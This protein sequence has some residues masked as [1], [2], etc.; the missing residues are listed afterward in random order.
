MIRMIPVS[1]SLL[2]V[3]LSACGNLQWPPNSERNSNSIGSVGLVNAPSNHIMAKV[4]KRTE[5][6]VK[7]LRRRHA[8]PNSTEHIVAAGETLWRIAQV[9]NVDIYELAILNQIQPPFRIF[10]GQS[11]ILSNNGRKPLNLAAFKRTEEIIVQEEFGS[12]DE[13]KERF[14][15]RATVDTFPHKNLAFLE[16]KPGTKPEKSNKKTKLLGVLKSS[17]KIRNQVTALKG[18]K[19]PPVRRGSRFIWPLNGKLISS[20]GAKGNGLHNDG[21]NIVAPMGTAVR[22]AGSGVVAYAGNELRGF[23]NLLLIKH[24]KG[25]VTAYAHNKTLIVRRGEKVRRGQVIAHVGNSGNVSRPQLH[26]EIRRG[27][28]AVD[29]IVSISRKKRSRANVKV[30]VS[31][32]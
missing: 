1:F 9:Y 5:R 16:I 31:K 17:P 25:W 27:N 13:R 30:S 29:P 26:F 11:L 7:N 24:G 32:R 6:I 4:T 10:V 22:A 23:G 2:V 3:M 8:K 21:I 19:L 15:K 14:E 12:N 20:F 28:K 18:S